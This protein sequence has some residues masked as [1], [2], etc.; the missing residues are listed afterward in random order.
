[1]LHFLLLHHLQKIFERE[2]KF[3]LANLLVIVTMLSKHKLKIILHLTCFT[4]TIIF[5][6]NLRSP[7]AGV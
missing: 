1:M 5:K 4:L 6:N 2:L 3:E 7:Y